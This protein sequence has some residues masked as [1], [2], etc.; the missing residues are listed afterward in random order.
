[1]ERNS[2][3]RKLLTAGMAAMTLLTVTA[4]AASAK[5]SA[6]TYTATIDCGSGPTTVGSTDDLFAPLVDLSSGKKYKPV[7]WD[8]VVDGQSFQ[9]S[10]GKQT[11]KHATACSYDDGVAV[12]TVTVKKA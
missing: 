7:A 10:Q 3:M 2:M 12:G 6:F 11:A 9:A 8:V 1:M 5:T 4:T